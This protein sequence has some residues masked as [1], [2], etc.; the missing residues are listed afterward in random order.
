[1]LSKHFRLAR[2]LARLAPALAAAVLLAGGAAPL[3]AQNL[4]K[5]PDFVSN[6]D[7]WQIIGQATWDGTLDAEGFPHEGSAKGV[8]DSSTVNGI[9]GGIV[10][11][12][13]LS[14]GTTYHFGGKIFIPA[15]N[16]ATGGAFFVMIPFPTG[17]CSGAPPPGP[18]VQTP[19][20][21]AVN[22]WNDSSTTFTDTFAKSGELFTA[23]APQSGGHFQA[24]YDDVVVA[25][26]TVTCTPDLHT[27]CLL[28]GGR[29]RVTVTFDTG[30][31]DPSNAQAVPIGNSGYFWF[32]NPANVEAVV[33]MIDGCGFGGHFW[34]FAAGLTNVHAVI[35]VTDT[36]SGAIQVYTNPANTAFQPI[37]DTS[38]FACP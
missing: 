36:Q 7:G 29:F 12:V 22:S 18:I 17:D 2:F 11:C 14:V 27:L 4:L 38:A 19:Q 30:N 6:L 5:N 34:F 35:T 28:A 13:P 3:P 10:Q 37:Q 33:K 21:I 25:T 26:G 16:T 32:F 8:F 31:G 1:M 15:G 24:N 20:V 23:L 9:S